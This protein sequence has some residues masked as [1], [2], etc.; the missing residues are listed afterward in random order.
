MRR[1][2]SSVSRLDIVSMRADANK[3][4]CK[5]LNQQEQRRMQPACADV[6]GQP[7]GGLWRQ[8]WT[9]RAKWYDNHIRDDDCS[10]SLPSYI[11]LCKCGW[12]DAAS[13][14]D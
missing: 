4:R 5:T 6:D 1:L 10:T 2:A 11:G 9:E 7:I 3:P 12:S 8:K 14:H 13:K